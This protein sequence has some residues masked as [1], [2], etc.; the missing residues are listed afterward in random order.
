ME[1]IIKGKNLSEKY[2]EEDCF[3]TE[4]LNTGSHPGL[5]VSKARVKP[6][7]T[8]RLHKVKGTEEKYYIL[9]GTGEMEI[10]GKIAGNVESSDIIIIPRNAA[11]RM[12]NTGTDDLI[13]L[14]ICTPRFEEKNYESLQTVN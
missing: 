8:T 13:F 9:A 10:D 6:G 12:K 5:S 7:I 11:Q 3:I 2:F 4:I 1:S 14:C